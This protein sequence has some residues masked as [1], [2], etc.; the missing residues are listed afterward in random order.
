[1]G[2]QC[3]GLSADA[4]GNFKAAIEIS[5]LNVEMYPQSTNVYDSLG[6]AYKNDGQKELAIKYYKKSLELNPENYNAKE[7]LKSLEEK[8]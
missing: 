7:M 2:I 4:R 1:M 6:V 8:K 5:K 3:T